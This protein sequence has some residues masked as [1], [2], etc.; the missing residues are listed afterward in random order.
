MP[1]PHE[2]CLWEAPGWSTHRRKVGQRKVSCVYRQY[3]EENGPATAAGS[4]WQLPLAL[5]KKCRDSGPALRSS[6]SKELIRGAPQHPACS[7]CYTEYIYIGRYD[8]KTQG[9]WKR[10]LEKVNCYEKA[11]LQIE[12]FR[13]SQDQISKVSKGSHFHHPLGKLFHWLWDFSIRRMCYMAK[14]FF[15]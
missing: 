4:C 1:Q 2:L 9:I 15:F 11:F 7:I 12:F 13:A 6:G 8:C 5:A 10:E 3:D 14:P